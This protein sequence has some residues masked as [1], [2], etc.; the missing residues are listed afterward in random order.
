QLNGTHKQAL[1]KLEQQYQASAKEEAEKHAQHA[2]KLEESFKQEALQKDRQHTAAVQEL[3]KQLS[4]QRSRGGQ[5]QSRL[6]AA[7]KELGVVKG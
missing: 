7:E 5:L 1:E 6:A 3:E 4:D 2:K